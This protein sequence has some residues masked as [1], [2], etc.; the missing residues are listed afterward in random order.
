[1][2]DGEDSDGQKSELE[3]AM[4][5]IKTSQS[6]LYESLNSVGKLFTKLMKNSMDIDEEFGDADEELGDFSEAEEDDFNH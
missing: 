4:H 6:I 1:V 5:E 3:N 2:T